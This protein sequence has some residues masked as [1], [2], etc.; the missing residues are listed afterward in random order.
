MEGKVVV[1][2]GGG[3]PRVRRRSKR[4]RFGKANRVP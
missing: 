3:D 4:G 2:G 1:G